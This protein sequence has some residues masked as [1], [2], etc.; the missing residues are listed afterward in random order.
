MAWIGAVAAVAGGLLSSSGSKKAAETASGASREELNYL[1]QSRDLARGDQAPYREAG[2][3]ALDAL[4]SM[5]GLGGPRGGT[6]G[7]VQT[8]GGPNNGRPGGRGSSGVT[9]PLGTGGG[10]GPVD[11]A[12]RQWDSS[13]N[14][15]RMT[16][17]DNWGPWGGNP[18]YPG[19]DPTQLFEGRA[20]GGPIA[21]RQLYNINEMGP[22]NVYSKG[23]YT[24]GKGPSTINGQTGYV[25]PNIQGRAEGGFM[26]GA[27]DPNFQPGGTPTDHGYVKTA[28]HS[29]PP[30]P[31]GGA[32]T[33]PVGAPPINPATGYPNENPGGVDGGYNF[34]TEPGYQFRFEEGQRALDRGAAAKGGL[35]SGGHAQKTIRYGQGMASQEFSNVYNRISN[36]A[37]LGQTSATNSGQ[38]AMQAGQGMGTAAAQGGYATAYGQQA[39]ANAW[40]KTIDD[41]K[42]EELFGGG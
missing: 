3:E 32:T 18:D 15:L 24:R 9:G 4:R 33:N 12:V 1:R 2:Y 26:G 42:W 29:G 34:M 11:A 39:G 35:L 14:P 38:Y 17:R 8:W 31:Y 30:A 27:Y 5:T 25:E 7:P 6:A 40:G 16:P 10:V 20:M 41:I 21:P 23:S 13:Y 37:G 22:E 36:I 19:E 28:P